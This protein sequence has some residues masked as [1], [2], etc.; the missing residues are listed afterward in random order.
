MYEQKS[1]LLFNGP[2]AEGRKMKKK[3]GLTTAPGFLM[4]ERCVGF[5]SD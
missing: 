4:K 3:K 1:D 2:N 5:Q